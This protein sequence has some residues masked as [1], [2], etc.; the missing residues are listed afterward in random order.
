[1]IFNLYA[2]NQDD[3]R[4]NWVFLQQDSW[5]W[6]LAPFYDVTFSPPSHREHATAF[7]GISKQPSL[8]V[9]QK[10]A[11]Q[12][13]FAS[14]E[15]AQLVIDEV[16]EAVQSFTC[17]A[18][19]LAIHPDVARLINKQLSNTYFQNKLLLQKK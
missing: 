2:L 9:M 4:K 6:Q 17:I 10:L 13:N 7:C 8:K 15:Q 16:V 19:K 1:M 5:Q 18:N 14:W 12:T 3:H 11:V